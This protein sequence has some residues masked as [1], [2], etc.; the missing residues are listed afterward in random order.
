MFDLGYNSVYQGLDIRFNSRVINVNW[1][2]TPLR[3]ECANGDTYEAD[4]VIVTM[5]LGVL[6]VSPLV[7]VPHSD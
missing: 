1:V 7:D 2:Q 3:V 6:K 5:S 4:H